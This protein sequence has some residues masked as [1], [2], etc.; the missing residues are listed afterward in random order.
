MLAASLLLGAHKASATEPDFYIILESCKTAVG[1]LVL[2]DESLKVLEGDPATF[3]CTRSSKVVSCVLAFP[4]GEP[5][6]KGST[7]DYSVLIDSPPY[8]HLT[9]KNGGEFIAIDTSKR[10]AVVLTRVLGQQYAGS[11]VCHGLF[12]TSFDMKSM[13]K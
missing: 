9:D 10:A 8:L 5:G 7:A 3:A 13:D 12:A 2:S 1:Y 4:G 6:H 11:K